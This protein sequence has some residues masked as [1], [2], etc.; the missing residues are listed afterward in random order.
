M[1]LLSAI[2]QFLWNG[3]LL[4]LLSGVHL[5]FT[6]RLHV[7]QRHIGRAIRMSLRPEHADEPSDTASDT[8]SNPQENITSHRR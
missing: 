6:I 2:N 7:P 5:Y 3:P 1:S 4:L 8:S